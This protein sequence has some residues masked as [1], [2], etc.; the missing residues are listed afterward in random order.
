VIVKL[1]NIKKYKVCI[2]KI[3]GVLRCW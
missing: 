3:I 1:D 2:R